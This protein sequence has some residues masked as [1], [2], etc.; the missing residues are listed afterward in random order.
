MKQTN[1]KGPHNMRQVGQAG[2]QAGEPQ[3]QGITMSCLSGAPQPGLALD[4]WL[5][6]GQWSWGRV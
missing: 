1:K 5:A 6:V 2:K 4:P 3:T